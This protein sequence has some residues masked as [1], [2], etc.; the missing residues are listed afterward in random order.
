MIRKKDART[1]LPLG[2][3]FRFEIRVAEDITD[4]MGNIHTMEI[5]GSRVELKK[6]TQVAVISTNADGI[7]QSPELCLGK[8]EVREIAAGEFY[9]VSDYVYETE[10]TYD[11][12]E[13][14]V[15]A[16]LFV[17]DEENDNNHSKR[18]L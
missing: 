17:E 10:L 11:R 7:A 5:E 12:A 14:S 13:I 18:R 16:E 9:A 6:G 2:E 4:P 1:Q 3:G 15:E 8:Y